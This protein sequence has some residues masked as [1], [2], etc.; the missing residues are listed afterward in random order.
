[1]AKPIV[2]SCRLCPGCWSV[3]PEG[4]CATCRKTDGI[5]YRQKQREAGV[6]RNRV[7]PD[8]VEITAQVVR[9]CLDYDPLTGEFRRKG[10]TKV[11]GALN[12]AGYVMISL[13]GWYFRAHRLAWAHAYGR[14]PASKLDHING[15]RN[16]NRIVN[17]REVSDAVNCQNLR[18]PKSNNRSGFLGVVWRPGPQKWAARITVAGKI[19]HLGLFESPEDASKA[20]LKAK[21]DLHEGCTV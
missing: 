7:R 20:Y 16:D 6:A 8:K 5:K 10:R 14:W 15:L 11:L 19:N 17:L 18:A 4:R 9:D 3:I 1:M 12:E 13:K 21:R 2:I